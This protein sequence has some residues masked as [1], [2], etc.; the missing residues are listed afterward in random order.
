[1]HSTKFVGLN[2]AVG[3]VDVLL[4]SPH[5]DDAVISAGN[6]LLAY[7][8]QKKRVCVVTI[9]TQGSDAIQ[10]P[11]V[12]TFLHNSGRGTASELFNKRRNE[13]REALCMLGISCY[14]HL[15]FTD[16]LFRSATLPLTT[17]IKPTYPSMQH[18]FGGRMSNQDHTIYMDIVRTLT[19]IK[20]LHTDTKTKVYAP[21]AVGNHVDHMITFSAVTSIF[22]TRTRF[23]EDVPYRSDNVQ[24]YARLA[25]IRQS[26]ISLS[27]MCVNTHMMSLR[28]KIAAAKYRSQ[29][30]GLVHN[31]MGDID[32]VHEVF[33]EQDN[34]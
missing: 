15:G 28:K 5:L 33:Y 29:W 6:M 17:L 23:W 13:D 34:L 18:V 21:L 30:S 16:A 10:T 19:K 32:M 20:T 26:G 14:T 9:F 24:L 2:Q 11:D 27:R 25:H 3:K 1:M 12:L 31:G 8:R 4:F 22:A 7:A